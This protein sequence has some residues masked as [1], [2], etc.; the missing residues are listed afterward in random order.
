MGY[1]LGVS[2]KKEAWM[3]DVEEQKRDEPAAERIDPAGEQHELETAGW[4]RL[5][6][7]GKVVW[8]S[9]ESGH[10]YPQGVAVARLREQQRGRGDRGDATEGTG[11]EV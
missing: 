6:R 11:D 2:K 1:T 9:P 8:R 10:L 7:Q 5:E 4:E 3:E